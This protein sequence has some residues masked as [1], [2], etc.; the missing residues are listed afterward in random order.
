MPAPRP[1]GGGLASEIA[2]PGLAAARASRIGERFAVSQPLRGVGWFIAAVLA[3][4][5]FSL[6]VLVGWAILITAAAIRVFTRSAVN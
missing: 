5:V 4:T 3:F 1:A 6:L 2:D